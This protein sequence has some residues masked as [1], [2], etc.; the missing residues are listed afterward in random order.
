M[1]REIKKLS[2]PGRRFYSSISS[3]PKYFNGLGTAIIST[4]KGVMSDYEARA[5]N[6][7]GE[8]LCVVF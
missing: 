3:L 2:K 7:G 4:S 8:V 5:A 6:V 1:I